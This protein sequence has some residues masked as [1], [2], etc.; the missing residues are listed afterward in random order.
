MKASEFQD[1]MTWLYLS[2]IIFSQLFDGFGIKEIPI[3]NET[4]I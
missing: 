2:S 1:R 4:F 3:L